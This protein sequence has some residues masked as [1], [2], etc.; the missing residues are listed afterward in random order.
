MFWFEN[1]TYPTF[2][3]A[4]L[5]QINAKNTEMKWVNS[6]YNNDA[7]GSVMFEVDRDKETY[8]QLFA[9]E[10]KADAELELGKEHGTQYSI[11]VCRN[12]EHDYTSWDGDDRDEAI[13][14]AIR[15][16]EKLLDFGFEHD[17]IHIVNIKEDS[18]GFPHK[19][20][21]AV[22]EYRDTIA[23]LALDS[24]PSDLDALCLFVQNCIGQTDGG[25][26]SVFWSG[27][28][29]D[30]IQELQDAIGSKVVTD[31]IPHDILLEYV[32]YEILS[33]FGEDK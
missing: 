27:H 30:G 6:S 3:T 1:E 26:A 32:E 31:S 22:A 14:Q 20:D 17:G 12:G 10:T 25:H 15:I 29:E 28:H 5:A 2:H 18:S 21:D 16:A 24:K 19:A 13:V 7:C 8:V 11:S 4:L 33:Y 9:F 23:T